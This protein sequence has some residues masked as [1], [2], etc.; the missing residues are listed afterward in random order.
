MHYDAGGAVVGYERTNDVTWC[1]EQREAALSGSV[2]LA[3]YLA[4]RD[5]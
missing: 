5:E 1:H 2:S 3:E 4:Q